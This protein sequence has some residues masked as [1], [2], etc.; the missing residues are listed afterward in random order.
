MI[1]VA[2]TPMRM[3]TMSAALILATILIFR[4]TPI[5]PITQ[6]RIV[7]RNWVWKKLVVVPVRPIAR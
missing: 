3:M 1:Q 7:A 6:K 4:P 2:V 5:K